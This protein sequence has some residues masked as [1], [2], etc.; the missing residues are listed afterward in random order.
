MIGD[1]DLQCF[2]EVLLEYYRDGK[3]PI[4]KLIRH[5]PLSAINEAIED[6]HSGKCIKAVLVP[7]S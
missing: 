2:I 7:G 6:H 3:L 5:Y 4:E 1:T